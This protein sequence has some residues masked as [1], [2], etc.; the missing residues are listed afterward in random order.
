MP[1]WQRTK[2]MINSYLDS[3]I[4]RTG[5]PESELRDVTRAEIAQLNEVEV[6]ARGAAKMIEKQ[7]AE[8]ELKLTGSTERQRM[9]RERGDATGEADAARIAAGFQQERDMLKSQ[10]AEANASVA[11]A[12]ALRDDRRNSVDDLAAKTHLTSMQ[13]TLAGMQTPF[14]AADPSGVIDEMRSKIRRGSSAPSPV[15]QADADLAAQAKKSKVDELLE[16]YKRGLDQGSVDP[17]PRQAS[18]L[19]PETAGVSEDPPAAPA[20]PGASTGLKPETE[21]TKTLGPA[22]GPVRPID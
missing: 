4:D 13:E 11:R 6:R 10:L 14:D 16:Q 9:C 1:M 15:E 21:E 3:L 19:A 20:A 2:R 22:S 7:L 18:F 8:A 12:R 5:R 17:I